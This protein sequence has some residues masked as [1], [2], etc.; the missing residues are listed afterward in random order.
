M[1]VLQSSK[2]TL[3]TM[4]PFSREPTRASWSCLIT[5]PRCCPTFT[6]I[7][8]PLPPLPAAYASAQTA[9]TGAEE[10]LS[11]APAAFALCRPPGHHAQKPR[12]NPS[13]CPDDQPHRRGFVLGL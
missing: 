9:I 4:W 2:C 3:T 12:P 13:A 5:A 8:A 6:P 1:G 11:G 10:I 7:A